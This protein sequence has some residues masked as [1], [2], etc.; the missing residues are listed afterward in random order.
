MHFYLPFVSGKLPLELQL[1]VTAVGHT[2]AC[3]EEEG[4]DGQLAAKSQE[5]ACS[6]GVLR[7]SPV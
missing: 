1:F 3:K 2:S 7:Y 6:C 5:I 4:G